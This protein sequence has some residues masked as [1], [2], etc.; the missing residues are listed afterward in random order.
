MSDDDTDYVSE[1]RLEVPEANKILPRLEKEGIR[2]RIDTDVSA[3][4]RRF[5]E[6]RIELFIHV[7]DV[8]AWEKIRMD[9]LPG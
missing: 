5:D 2:F 1:G 3:H 7:D 8:P 9:Y 6:A 4:G